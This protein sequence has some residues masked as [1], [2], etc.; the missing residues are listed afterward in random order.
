M[1]NAWLLCIVVLLPAS[2]FAQKFF[3]GKD[4][5]FAEIAVGGGYE[6][7]LNGN[8]RA[9]SIYNGTLTLI[10]SDPSEP[11]SLLL[12]GAAVNGG[13]LSLPYRCIQNPYPEM[14]ILV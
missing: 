8:N 4:M 9:T 11:F 3:P 13:R 5:T 1:K 2:D 10:P 7:I 14:R 6:T 12:N